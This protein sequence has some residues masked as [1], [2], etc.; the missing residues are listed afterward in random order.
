MAARTVAAFITSGAFFSSKVLCRSIIEEEAFPGDT[1]RAKLFT[2][3]RF[4]LE[5]PLKQLFN[6]ETNIR[7]LDDMLR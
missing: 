4:R 5:R 3:G 2:I 6:N 1:R 7:G